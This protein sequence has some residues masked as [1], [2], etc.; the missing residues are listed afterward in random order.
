MVMSLFSVTV[1]C[2]EAAS[3]RKEP[4]PQSFHDFLF[5]VRPGFESMSYLMK[6]ADRQ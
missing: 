6:S 1:F 3:G 4:S 5:Q 2:D